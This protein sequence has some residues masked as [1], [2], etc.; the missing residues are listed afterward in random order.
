MDAN[1]SAEELTGFSHEELSRM[2]IFDLRPP[3]E[4]HLTVDYL[5]ALMSDDP[6]ENHEM[7]LIKKDGTRRAIVQTSKVLSC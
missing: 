2:N 6:V 3:K 5:K 4:H 1:V 7:N